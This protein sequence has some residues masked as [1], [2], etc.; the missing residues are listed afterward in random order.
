MK[1]VKD[2]ESFGTYLRDVRRGNGVTRSGLSRD[3]GVAERTLQRYETESVYLIPPLWKL[4]LIADVYNIEDN[5]ILEVYME[6]VRRL[7]NEKG[8]RGLT[9]IPSGGK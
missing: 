1:I 3:S 2:F 5:T 7:Y 4:E 6:S 8:I 9:D